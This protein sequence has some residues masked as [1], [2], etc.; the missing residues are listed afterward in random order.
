V[1]TLSY[2]GVK[3]EMKR[4]WNCKIPWAPYKIFWALYFLVGPLK[5]ACQKEYTIF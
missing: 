4:R 3:V 1:T 5:F 2:A